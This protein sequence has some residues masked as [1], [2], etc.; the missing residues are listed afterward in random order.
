MADKP[1][2][3]FVDLSSN[4]PVPS[5]RN[6]RA[7]YRAGR[8]LIVLKVSEGT[9]YTWSDSHRLSG[10]WH[11]LG[12]RVGH[13][14]W[15][16]PGGAAPGTEQADY[17]WAHVKADLQDGDILI[18]DLEQQGATEAEHAAFQTRLA[19]LIEISGKQL[20]R[21]TYSGAYF[22]RSIKAKPHGTGWW[23]AGYP[24]LP[25]TPAG[26]KDPVAHQFT[27][28]ANSPGLPGTSDESRLL[29]PLKP[30]P[31]PHNVSTKG[32]TKKQRSWIRRAVDYLR[33]LNK[34]SK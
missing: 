3:L 15:T 11:K 33:G 8:R 1:A 24:S 16:S 34:G 19:G 14:H 26:W 23:G 6:L 29:T 28:K 27:D 31:K 30:V 10:V 18:E 7:H 25:F 5:K 9:G 22:L 2:A 4:N 17:F 32:L 13:Y 21:W 20:D 12:G